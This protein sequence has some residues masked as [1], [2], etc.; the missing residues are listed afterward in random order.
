MPRV[1]RN[2]FIFVLFE[3]LQMLFL[4]AMWEVN[5]TKLSYN[6][7]AVMGLLQWLLNI[8]YAKYLCNLPVI[9]IPNIFS[10]FSFIFNWYLC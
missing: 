2:K 9:S 8:V 6:F 7:L 5:K 4:L 3:I 1:N 10:F